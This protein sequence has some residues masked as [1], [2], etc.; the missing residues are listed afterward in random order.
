MKILF[1]E[2][3]KWLLFQNQQVRNDVFGYRRYETLAKHLKPFS[4]IIKVK[5]R[6]CLDYNVRFL[7][8]GNWKKM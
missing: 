4:K 7:P 3:Y 5:R 1:L 6:Q 8:Q 2:D